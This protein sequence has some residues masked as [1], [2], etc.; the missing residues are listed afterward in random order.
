MPESVQLS[1]QQVE[2][3]ID[4][5]DQI[6]HKASNLQNDADNLLNQEF[7]GL[8]QPLSRLTNY[9]SQ[10]E[11]GISDALDSINVPE[12]LSIEE[13]VNRVE[14]SITEYEQ[15][16]VDRIETEI[17][18]LQDRD[19]VWFTI[20]LSKSTV[21]NDYVLDV[22]SVQS[23][24][25]TEIA[26]DVD[27][28]IKGKIKVGVDVGDFDSPNEESILIKVG[29]LTLGAV[30]DGATV[31]DV[32]ASFGIFDLGVQ[33]ATV[34][35]NATAKLD[36]ITGDSE[37]L[38]LGE[39]LS[40]ED[41]LLFDV[42]IPE[43]AE[44]PAIRIV[45]P[46]EF[47]IG[48]LDQTDQKLELVI[49]SS[50]RDLNL[51][52]PDITINGR[53]I[54]DY[55]D[56]MSQ[57]SEE[58][59]QAY[60]LEL[61]RWLP[62]LLG[63]TEIPVINKTLN[64]LIDLNDELM[65]F[66]D[67]VRDA[68]DRLSF[69]G[70]NQ[71]IEQL[72]NELNTM[73]NDGTSGETQVDL[74]LTWNEAREALEWTLP[75]S[76][77]L[78]AIAPFDVAQFIPENVRDLVS[79]MAEGQAAVDGSFD[80]SVT[81]GIAIANPDS[82]I[83][84]TGESLL[85][86]INSGVGLTERGL[87]DD[88]SDLR[89][90]LSD[91]TI[92]DVDLNG[93]ETAV[94]KSGQIYSV[95]TTT[96]G[97]QGLVDPDSA[98]PFVGDATIQD[99][100]DYLNEI[101]AQQIAGH[102]NGLFSVA[103]ENS[104]LVFTD[105]TTGS[106]DFAINSITLD[107]NF[108]TRDIGIF[109]ADGTEFNIDV[110]GSY[111]FVTLP[112]ATGVTP[113][114]VHLDGLPRID[115]DDA[116]Q[117][118]ADLLNILN[119]A[120]TLN[121][122]AAAKFIA[123]IVDGQIQIDDLT[124]D[125][126]TQARLSQVSIDLSKADGVIS[127]ADSV[128]DIYTP[129]DIIEMS[130]TSIASLVLG[131][132]GAQEGETASG[133]K[134][135][136]GQSLE[137]LSL[138][139]RLYIKANE[140]GE[141]AVSGDL[142]I[143]VDFD[144]GLAL[145]PLSY[146][147]DAAELVGYTDFT[148]SLVDPG[149]GEHA[150]GLIFMSELD[151]ASYED[152]INSQFVAP[153]ISGGAQLKLAPD[154]YESD[155][156]ID[157][158]KYVNDI[159][160]VNHN[161]DSPQA[162]FNTAL[163]ASTDEV[164]Y[165]QLVQMDPSNWDFVIDSSN[166]LNEILTE[167][168]NFSWDDLPR[169]LNDIIDYLKQTELWDHPIPLTGYS[170]GDMLGVVQ[171]A[172]EFAADS[173]YFV[174]SKWFG[175]QATQSSQQI[176]WNF[177]DWKQFMDDFDWQ[178][179]Q[180]T[181]LADQFA[182]MFQQLTWELGRLEL[183][184]DNTAQSDAIG[185]ADITQRL[186]AWKT[187]FEDTYV[188]YLE[189]YKAAE[190]TFLDATIEQLKGIAGYF[191]GVP[192]G[193]DALVDQLEKFFNENV[194]GC[195]AQI[196]PTLTYENG[197]HELNLDLLLNV[198]GQYAYDFTSLDILDG[199]AFLDITS[200]GEVALGLK[201][202]L[203]A[204]FNLI[205][206]TDDS[207]NND[208]D[209][210]MGDITANLAL[211]AVAQDLSLMANLGG[212]ANVAIGDDAETR[213]KAFLSLSSVSS[214]EE[215]ITAAGVNSAN[216]A[217]E[218]PD[219]GD[220][221]AFVQ[222]A[223]SKP[224]TIN[225]QW[226]AGDDPSLTVDSYLLT[227]LPI[228]ADGALSGTPPAGEEAP[229]ASLLAV[230]EYDSTVNTTPELGSYFDGDLTNLFDI[231][232]FGSDGWIAGAYDFIQG[233]RT[234]LE[235]DFAQNI[236]YVNDI[237][238]D[239]PE[240]FDLYDLQCVLGDIIWWQQ[241]DP[242]NTDD[243]RLT[244]DLK[245]DIVAKGLPDP[246]NNEDL[247]NLG[248]LEFD[249]FND[250]NNTIDTLIKYL[251][252]V[253]DNTHLAYG[254]EYTFQIGM[255]KDYITLD[256]TQT[257]FS[258]EL[259]NADGASTVTYA[260][261]MAMSFDDLYAYE[262]ID[263]IIVNFDFATEYQT[264]FP[265]GDFNFG[266]DSLGIG[267]D[268]I[269]LDAEAEMGLVTSVGLNLGMGLGETDGFFVTGGDEPAEVTF[270]LGI[271]F[272]E[273]S[274][275]ALDLGLFKLAVTDK[276][277]STSLD[278]LDTNKS[279]REISATVGIDLVEGKLAGG[280]SQIADQFEVTGNVKAVID[281]Q[282]S[283][284]VGDKDAVTTGL[285]VGFYNPNAADGTVE[286]VYNANTTFGDQLNTD[287]FKFNL[288]KFELNL[289]AFLGEVAQEAIAQLKQAFDPLQPI[290][291]L[292]TGEVPLLS[293]LSEQLGNDPVSFVDA[294]RW[295][296]DPE[297]A[298]SIIEVIEFLDQIDD[299]ASLITD[300]GAI[301]LGGLV[302]DGVSMIDAKA[303]QLTYDGTDASSAAA[304]PDSSPIS[305]PIID[306]MSGQ[307]ANFIFG[308]NAE[309]F[310]WN[311][312]DFRA[313]FDFRQSFPVFPPLNV[314]LFGGVDFTTNFDL[315]YDTRGIRLFTE[316]YDVLELLNG[317]Y[318]YDDNHLNDAIDHDTEL[319]LG[320]EIGAGAELNVA[321][322]AAGVEGGLRGELGADLKDANNDGKVY[323]DEFIYN[324]LRGPEC[325][326]DYS[327]SLDVFL[328]AYLKVGLDTPF[329]FVTLY[330]TNMKLAE[331]TLLDWSMESC[332]P[333]SPTLA[334]VSND[335]KQLELNIGTRAGNV[336]S[337]GSIQDGD[338][339][340]FVDVIRDEAGQPTDKGLTV[341]AHGASQDFLFA[342]YGNLEV[343]RFDAGIGNDLVT[344][345]PEVKLAVI[346]HGGDGIDTLVGGSGVNELYGDAGD[347]L[348][349]GR[350]NKDKLYG[351]AGDDFLYGYGGAD[352][353][354][355]GD[356]NDFI[357]GEDDTGDLAAFAAA[358]PEFGAGVEAK[359]TILGGKG[360]D[361]IVAGGGDDIVNGGDD[362]DTIYAGVGN[363][364][365]QGGKGNDLIFGE[366]GN[367][368]LWGD[369]DDNSVTGGSDT[370]HAD[371]IIGGEGADI[372][373]GG[374]GNDILFATT[375]EAESTGVVTVVTSNNF[376]SEIY[377]DDGADTI[378]GTANR[379]KLE[380]GS[381]SDYINSGDGDDFVYGGQGSDA[382][383]DGDGNSEIYG[384]FGNDVIDGGAGDDVIEGG[385]GDDQIYAREGADTVYGGT[386]T[387]SIDLVI[388]ELATGVYTPQH[389]GFTSTLEENGC[390]PEI[391]FY[392]EVYNPTYGP[393]T[394]TIFNDLDADG[395]RDSGESFVDS[396]EW[397]V[398]LLG[399]PTQLSGILSA[400][401]NELQNT[402]SGLTLDAGQYTFVVNQAGDG[403]TS[404]DSNQASFTV[405]QTTGAVNVAIGFTTSV[406]GPTKDETGRIVGTVTDTG[407]SPSNPGFAFVYLDSNENLT[408]DSGEAITVTDADGKYAFD[409]LS[410]G[411]DYHVVVHGLSNKHI[412][413][414]DPL[415]GYQ[416]VTLSNDYVTADFDIQ[417]PPFTSI[418]SIDMLT[419]S[420]DKYELR[421]GFSQ[422]TYQFLD[423]SEII[424]F[425]VELTT[426]RTSQGVFDG[427]VTSGL[428]L[429]N[430]TENISY[431]LTGTVNGSVLE[432]LISDT[433][434]LLAGSYQLTIDENVSYVAD[435]LKNY[436]LGLDGE[437]TTSVSRFVS[438]DGVVGGDFVFEFAV[439]DLLTFPGM[440]LDSQSVV[441]ATD[442][443]SDLGQADGL[444]ISGNVWHHDANSDNDFQS[445]WED[446]VEGQIIVLYDGAYA[447]GASLADHE[448]ARVT[449]NSSGEY[450]FTGLSAGEYVV[451]QLT[452]ND[453]V[454]DTGYR[455]GLIDGDEK[456][457]LEDTRAGYV[458][459]QLN[460]S[461]IHHDGGSFL[462]LNGSVAPGGAN[463]I[464][465]GNGFVANDVA[466]VAS[467]KGVTAYISG[468]QYSESGVYSLLLTETVNSSTGESTWI[469]DGSARLVSSGPV[470]KA[471]DA[472]SDDYLVGVTANAEL[473]WVDATSVGDPS[474]YT[475]ISTLTTEGGKG[476]VLLPPMG[477]LV[478]SAG[479]QYGYLLTAFA[480]SQKLAR[481]DLFTG[482]VSAVFNIELST[483]LF[484]LEY[485]GDTLV[486]LGEDNQLYTVHLTSS[487][488]IQF[489][490]V[491]SGFNDDASI[492]SIDAGGLAY[493]SW[494]TDFDFSTSAD[495]AVSV[496][497]TQGADV[498]LGFGDK[499]A[500]LLLDGNDYVDGGCG[501]G[502]DTLNGDDLLS[503]ASPDG[504]YADRDFVLLGG[505]DTINGRGGN[506]TITGGMQSDTLLG[507]DGDDIIYG[508]DGSDF[509]SPDEGN[510]IEGGDGNDSLFGGSS[511]DYILGGNGDDLVS[512][513]A[514]NDWLY[515][516]TGNDTLEGG[517]GNDLLVGG[518]G[519]DQVYGYN[520]DD[521]L[522]VVHTALGD[523]YSS[524]PIG[525]SGNGGVYSGGEGTDSIIAVIDDP[526]GITANATS[527][528]SVD[529][530]LT[531]NSI[532]ISGLAEESVEDVEKAL[533]ETGDGD[534]LIDAEAFSGDAVLIGNDGNDTLRSGDGNDKLYGGL[535]ENTLS[536]E[537]GADLYVI[538][539]GSSN[540][541]VTDS[542]TSTSDD[543]LKLVGLNDGDD[544]FVG[545]ADDPTY[546]RVVSTDSSAALASITNIESISVDTDAEVSS[547]DFSGEDDSISAEIS[548]N[549]IEVYLR[550]QSV[551]NANAPHLQS[552]LGTSHDDH[553]MF[554]A[555][556]YTSASI[557]G[558]TG[559]DTLNYSKY[560]KSVT[561]DLLNDSASATAGVDNM[562][563]VIG[564]S[565][566]DQITGSAGKNQ[567]E[568]GL[569]SDQLDGGD[570]T[571][572]AIFKGLMKDYTIGNYI[573]AA[574]PL[575]VTD[576][577]TGD[578][579][580][581]VNFE[582]LQFDDVKIATKSLLS[583][584]SF[585]YVYE[586]HTQQVLD[587]ATLITAELQADRNVTAADALA[588]LKLAVGLNPNVGDMPISPYQVM[589][590]DVNQDGRVSAADALSVLKMAVGIDSAP[591]PQWL[592]A[593]DTFDF[594][595]ETNTTDVVF[596]TDDGKLDWT[597]ID[598]AVGQMKEGESLVAV[599]KG[600]VNGSWK[601]DLD[602]LPKEYFAQL[603]EQF[604]APMEQ[605]WLV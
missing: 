297:S 400:D 270:D 252:E 375:E 467:D 210:Q 46:F 557:D 512:G 532:Q 597:S 568:G 74:A 582:Y 332:P 70:I 540:N 371:K 314:T 2:G 56:K 30:A 507:G 104:R 61:L 481:I 304:T 110:D 543:T 41:N 19:R 359:D 380:G 171:A 397:S 158:T 141:S 415:G 4:A 447:D 335:G 392:P 222:S 594:W 378:Y 438:G 534:D 49:E 547:L 66:V 69:R 401:S 6:I 539:S 83:E 577:A 370:V 593:P 272:M 505:N 5:I 501:D 176:D 353:L 558:L 313:S 221:S 477:D 80:F 345:T 486:A 347:D 425:D 490:S 155:W 58:D 520:G 203:N 344:I 527:S 207:L 549:L 455:D 407:A 494:Q 356:G 168:F 291:D 42:S 379:D 24:S 139:D 546:D 318:L 352:L 97:I 515:G 446:D 432:I 452:V 308:G 63:N 381:G 454:N 478:V 424:G 76:V 206:S 150:D 94:T 208:I 376:A 453:R 579:D 461:V 146:A 497:L 67:R 337:D 544:V 163:A 129:R 161:L 390:G 40:I 341:I 75:Y 259:T 36:L 227:Y 179:D 326:L 491:V 239:D 361:V 312:P 85:D 225:F 134:T 556:G 8:S 200:S 426:D 194:N 465:L 302:A 440:V 170:L 430:L 93:S 484:G 591:E 550:G 209:L 54:E 542:G 555:D 50:G 346:G 189:E 108:N 96:A 572:I 320:A 217:S 248:S 350:G 128:F 145:G 230:V 288:D 84:I 147:L 538:D 107:T 174:L 533:L 275:V 242:D 324:L 205:F 90:T 1:R 28:E 357:Y 482:E 224:A 166:K 156:N 563:N 167:G 125:P 258:K 21:L 427:Q 409:D 253:E 143:Q 567:I 333:E 422:L 506:D 33:T 241:S 574:T 451:K 114:V 322:A 468:S 249:S 98:V 183:A 12:S 510:R 142:N 585:K 140:E 262:E 87:T 263:D 195:T 20:D 328:R 261:L 368:S 148:V 560:G 29:S 363:D 587:E 603:Q 68:Y 121:D 307:L 223:Q 9:A 592:F 95:A 537:Q 325:I 388:D 152:M 243:A 419:Q 509:E 476:D 106:N 138:Y 545:A 89:I 293:K 459:H 343:I 53:P 336:L 111:T 14:R 216:D 522:I 17:E 519:V 180:S 185:L 441:D 181:D 204:D 389:G 316:E 365:I 518:A 287:Y 492:T 470:L 460:A 164:P 514:G 11:N 91:G 266:I 273:G 536:S 420:G 462:V 485:D 391:Y 215:L 251:F 362:N 595:D 457:W 551:L 192:L 289:E 269:G 280:F 240:S 213:Q 529:V 254:D 7:T 431:A 466:L 351:D 184:W 132:W 237:P 439:K 154:T 385:A 16:V 86:E 355:G 374:T 605:W 136:T 298:E 429:R 360:E 197:T 214:G 78:S 187:T 521:K 71:F 418:A 569:G 157:P 82:A 236:P 211:S 278:K 45:I 513:Q 580:S 450:A 79:I 404:T 113:E 339:V 102:T 573:T 487:L 182:S 334:E 13:F 598:T 279:E 202:D 177:R 294:F 405:D 575:L 366:Q 281:A 588:T 226:L 448:V 584:D 255:D 586:W 191:K 528:S 317:L 437:W 196:T 436:E 319:V 469:Q 480:G 559:V 373:R 122:T 137:S 589:A 327:G 115:N 576:K 238:L 581:L 64:E 198:D 523:A 144:G 394:I 599:L 472:F 456:P 228:Y 301:I 31:D 277:A 43:S 331:A 81:G 3:L 541:V 77:D 245:K 38:T 508:Y 445:S 303:S 565:F 300:K 268:G 244:D 250:I 299:Y 274:E 247:N 234:I 15:F 26:V 488:E 60:L 25:A 55:F 159:A 530:V 423:V 118:V 464:Y 72:T 372:I 444:T 135:L 310:A 398:N 264:E 27:G 413:Y 524:A 165:I 596:T 458:E 73:L 151:E 578:V 416:T 393:V 186:F 548:D 44:D 504:A 600:D 235:T 411:D 271:G 117:K 188:R 570:D 384:G 100:L 265:L 62:E 417:S 88:A 231:G 99:L 260:Q 109:L 256:P 323:T 349:S 51:S 229:D 443:T 473:Y 257:S 526:T 321:V 285:T 101:G 566:D 554:M 315:G 562:E 219:Y 133:N 296:G 175:E 571:D 22:S 434:D 131:M 330:Q 199:G 382:L 500:T 212:L 309:I 295:F 387:G 602:V 32:D 552:I 502:D 479:T 402:L 218:V 18:N 124:A 493:V 267:L 475:F 369:L 442:A 428:S 201:G 286:F 57:M 410:V 149:E 126:V 531:D 503:L 276:T 120:S 474:A 435:S 123:K 48:G 408:W 23:L 414:L 112:A 153:T 130:S 564:S 178:W 471:L 406:D 516:E 449:T 395:V 306:D 342:T 282:L 172:E 590:A 119:K 601:S 173:M 517:D 498:Y 292:V 127:E 354:D 246:R 92:V 162:V 37:Y 377:G 65:E 496:N 311:I 340:F 290:I 583:F 348:L 412:Q 160:E 35:L 103:I 483:K 421:D 47:G 396:G 59:I 561:V 284:K 105:L 433:K 553:F 283:Q 399:G 10:I 525:T 52:W 489:E 220:I 604:I 364:F 383:I 495:D 358:N 190:E 169:Y 535:G 232:D 329:G 34:D 367:D 511:S 39:V 386:S 338:E 403:W 233:A 463:S 499:L 116:S 305:F 193:L